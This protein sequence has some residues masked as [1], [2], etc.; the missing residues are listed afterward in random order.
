M[1]HL[2]KPRTFKASVL[3]N[4][5][6]S[7]QELLVQLTPEGLIRFRQPR[8]RTWLDFPLAR[9]YHLAALAAADAIRAARRKVPGNA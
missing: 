9:V 4:G 8:R 3:L 7:R 2:T 6:R 1:I 5:S